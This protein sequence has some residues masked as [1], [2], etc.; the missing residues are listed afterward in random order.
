MMS[1]VADEV[2]RRLQVEPVLALEQPLRQVEGR[3][4][5]EAPARGRTARRTWSSPAP[6]AVLRVPLH[7]AERQPQR[8]RRVRDKC[9]CR[10][11]R[12]APGRSAATPLFPPLHLLLDALRLLAE[13]RLDAPRKRDDRIGRPPRLPPARPRSA[14]CGT[15]G[16]PASSVIDFVGDLRRRLAAERRLDV[17]IVRPALLERLP[18]ASASSDLV[19]LR[20]HRRRREQA[21][22]RS[23][24][25]CESWNPSRRSASGL[26]GLLGRIAPRRSASDD[27]LGQL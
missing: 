6:L 21:G 14:S 15:P 16:R 19:H 3:L 27:R 8:E 25:S 5:A 23:D 20:I 18:Q 11:P 22:T 2:E 7:R 17:R 10:R 24:S 13:D 4:A 12:T 1:Q 26:G 9:S